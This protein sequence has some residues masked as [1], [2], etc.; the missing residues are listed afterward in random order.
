[1]PDPA[2]ASACIY[3]AS[4]ALQG[5]L[6]VAGFVSKDR[7]QGLHRVSHYTYD[8]FQQI[9]SYLSSLKGI[10]DR[11][12]EYVKA[13]RPALMQDEGFEQ[14]VAEAKLI[15]GSLHS[16]LSTTD[17]QKLMRAF[18]G[19]RLLLA[20]VDAP[21]YKTFWTVIDWVITL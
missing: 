10:L 6:A 2:I 13:F 14:F 15:L 21:E 20:L 4:A 18:Q 5:G 19:L 1:M 9:S 16:Q 7:P 3:G 17:N 11:F 8:T 12:R